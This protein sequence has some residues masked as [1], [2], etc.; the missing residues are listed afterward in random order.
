MPEEK[1]ERVKTIKAIKET[2]WLAVSVGIAIVISGLLMVL[3]F[4]AQA[5][6]IDFEGTADVVFTD[7]GAPEGVIDMDNVRVMDVDGERI[8]YY[9]LTDKSLSESEAQILLSNEGWSR[10]TLQIDKGYELGKPPEN[11]FRMDGDM[12]NFVILALIPLFAI[13]GVYIMRY[14]KNIRQ[15]EDR[16]PDFLR[17]V[18]EAGRFGMTLAD[19]IVVAS[20]GRYGKLTPE[21]KKMAA[22]IDWGVPANEAIKLFSDKVKTPLVNRV[23]AIIMKSND[24]GGNVA[25]VLTL[26]ANDTKQVQLMDKERKLSMSTYIAVIYISFF[27]FLFT[28]II[29]NATFLPQMHKAGEETSQLVSGTEAGTG[30]VQIIQAQAISAIQF[31]YLIA[32]LAHAMGDGLIAGSLST[33]KIKNGLVHSFILLVAAFVMLRLLVMFGLLGV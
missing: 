9:T 14:D 23:C 29:L 19:A 20:G 10:R 6:T 3:A 32:S 17:D 33:G 4:L 18:A 8:T 27:V 13:P 24:A 28:I 25:D 31:T 2:N 5:G 30:A 11:P 12:I 22:R 1:T 7:E 21:I 15:I 26:V 16:L